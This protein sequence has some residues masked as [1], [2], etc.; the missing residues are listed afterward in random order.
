LSNLDIRKGQVLLVV[1]TACSRDHLI[2]RL[3]AAPTVCFVVTW[4]FW[5]SDLSIIQQKYY[6]DSGVKQMH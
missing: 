5:R 1:G 4:I 2:S 3:Q 6:L